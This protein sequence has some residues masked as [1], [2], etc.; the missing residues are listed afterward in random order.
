MVSALHS[1]EAGELIR[2]RG[3]VQ[4]V[5][6]RPGVWRLATEHG[7][8]G[9]VRNDADGVLIRIWGPAQERRRFLNRLRNEAPPPARI[10]AV[11]AQPLCD[12]LP[13]AGFHI[14][15]NR[16]GAAHAAIA[17]DAAVCR[18]CLADIEDGRGRRFRYAFT[19]CSRCGP[20]LSIV[21]GIP[22]DRARTSMAEFIQCEACR[23]EYDDPA[24]RRFR[25]QPNACPACGPR[26]ALWRG[27]GAPL[28]AT[29]RDE[30]EI[31]CSLLRA[32]HII[33]LKGIGGFHLAADAT[34]A[35]A[36]EELRRRKRCDHK[37]LA[38]MAPDLDTVRRYCRVGEEEAALLA[39]PPAP[40]VIL[41]A[42]GPAS[43]P[44]AI[45]PGLDTLGFMLPST[46]LHHLL[47]RGAG[48]PLVMTSG[49]IT[50]EPQCIDNAEAWRRLGG[51]ADAMLLHDR[52]IVNRLDDSVVR[53]MAGLPRVIRRARGYAPAPLSLPAGLDGAPPLLAMGGE[54]NAGFCI[55]EDGG[56]MPSQ[57]LGDLE[58]AAVRL[59]YRRS[60]ALYLEMYRHRPVL[61]AIDA[62]PGY[63]SAKRGRELAAQHAVPVLEVQ[64]HHA[65]LASC[66]AENAV[67]LDARPV[68]GIVFDG[69]GCG[70]DGALWGGEFLL[71]DYRCFTRLAHLRPVP[72]PGGAQAIH[73]PWRS[74][75]AHLSAAFGWH[76][77]RQRYGG[78]P[79]YD[80]LAAHLLAT[81]DR[82]AAQEIDS[83]LA[84]SCGRLVD[85]VAAALGV[86][87]ERAAY[88]GQAA[89][90]LE[91]LV[92][93]R[94]LAAAGEGYPFAVE[95]RNGPALL[96]P[97]PMWRAL[98]DDMA[99]GVDGRLIAARFH[100]GLA[101]AVVDMTLALSITR[102]G[103][104]D[105][106][107]LSGGAFQNRVLLERA[108]AGLEAAGLR[109]LTQAQVP[110]DDGGLALG[111]A[112][113]AAAR[114]M[115][116]GPA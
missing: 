28:A 114:L 43:L 13:P 101:R 80:F 36:I 56:A 14:L 9:D 73:E 99:R 71:G 45:A 72:M 103:D 20:R 26:L 5:G 88:E 59:D 21:N 79:L 1:R 6:M 98:V 16:E 60:L 2:L 95:T 23:E 94:S 90:Q 78:L 53:V 32:G 104:F 19:N 15:P 105:S 54:V 89:M 66:L 33:A 7:L 111:Q 30:I 24:G 108:A 40:I 116:A 31:A 55:A 50:D 44:A 76:G 58:H 100:A 110:A 70:G 49:N 25:A 87:R 83:P 27:D 8:S 11:E 57:H 115:E 74:T 4:G 81:P 41:R 93:E 65:H 67:P 92:D 69:G 39:S 64:H 107:A 3:L 96:D 112:A 75:H 48:R 34:N 106:V 18:D 61:I 102:R 97:A 68:L 12:V 82:A 85:A 52:D 46:P 42:E 109:V 62:H 63:L 29:G 35:A 47:T 37:P 38:L 10:D 86:C 77:F 17:P 91:A 51:L 113:V 84:G 22:Y